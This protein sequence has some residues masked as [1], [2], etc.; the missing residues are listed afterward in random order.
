MTGSTAPA[1]VLQSLIISREPGTKPKY[2]LQ[3]QESPCRRQKTRFPH[4]KVTRF[5]RMD[6]PGR[7]QHRTG[8]SSKLSL[9]DPK[10]VLQ[11]SQKTSSPTRKKENEKKEQ[12]KRRNGL[13]KRCSH[14]AACG[15]YKVGIAG[16]EERKERKNHHLLCSSP[17]L[18]FPSRG[19][20]RQEEQPRGSS[21]R[22]GFTRASRPS[23]RHVFLC[24]PLRKAISHT[25]LF[26]RGGR[27]HV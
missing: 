18:V 25:L 21:W 5:L 15:R 2:S 7:L 13:R 10:V 6:P 16:K 23:R 19:Q 9:S 20:E 24:R 27:T 1:V 3:G 4:P 8:D 12:R 22:A 14:G 17:C 11:E 26:P